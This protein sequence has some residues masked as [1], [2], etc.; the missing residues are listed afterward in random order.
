[1]QMCRL[2]YTRGH[3]LCTLLGLKPKVA[4]EQDLARV[5]EELNAVE[6]TAVHECKQ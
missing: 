5:F 6:R 2:G 3:S 4:F 1:M